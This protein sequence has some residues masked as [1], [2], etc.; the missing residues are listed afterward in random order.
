MKNGK[1]SI[2]I[3]FSARPPVISPFLPPFLARSPKPTVHLDVY[4]KVSRLLPTNCIRACTASPTEISYNHSDDPSELY[5]AEI[6]FIT[7]Q[8]WIKELQILFNDLLDGNGAVSRDCSNA[9]SE[10]G[11][12]YAK[13]KAVYPHKTKEMIA[14]GTPQDFANEPAVRGVLGSVKIL[15]E[16]SAKSL[17]SRLQHY[18]D[19]K[20]KITGNENRKRNVPMEYWPLIK[21]VRIYTKAKALST[22]AVLV[23]L[24]SF[25]TRLVK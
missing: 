23:D 14:E 24:V 7:A 9:D 4:L 5:R 20:E 2:T 8:E 10:A 16:N 15:K 13:L 19:S 22:G 11:V 12:A 17:Y 6:E 1:I 18:V 3:A 21:V 25:S